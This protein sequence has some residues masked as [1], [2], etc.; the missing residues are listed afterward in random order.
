MVKFYR[1]GRWSQEAILDEHRFLLD[2]AQSDMPVV[3]P[4][5]DA[6]GDTL[7]EHAVSQGAEET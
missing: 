7:A 3:P 6:D 1:P 4:L 5:Q 2:C